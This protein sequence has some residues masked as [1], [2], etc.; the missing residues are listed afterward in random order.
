MKTQSDKWPV[1]I[2]DDEKMIHESLEI[3]LASIEHEAKG[4]ELLHAYS[5]EEAKN[6]LKNN[7]EIAVILLDVMMEEDT[8]GLELVRFIKDE[9]KNND[10][11]I[12]LNTG[13]P[14]I[15]PKKEVAD[16]YPI[17]GYLDKNITDN[18]D[19]Y[20]AVRSALRSYSDR[21]RLKES[22]SKT[23]IELLENIAEHYFHLL[24]ND[25]SIQ[26]YGEILSRINSMVH[27]SQEILASY[28]L[29]DLKKDLTIGTTKSERL[30]FEE[31][32]SLIQIHN[33]KII[34]SQLSPD[35]F[36]K[37][38]A[39]LFDTIM[40]SARNF[41]LIKILPE[42]SKKKIETYLQS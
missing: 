32:S 25:K 41:L 35:R 6:I 4:V 42:Q 13:Q 3:S 31:Y 22:A 15:A 2:V 26:K 29:E 24:S 39:I 30:S 18:D 11:R 10:V 7:N 40:N 27:C 14:G 19:T 5:K 20:A 1:L 8:A 9:I 36:Q 17:D 28:T 16:Q 38:I 37:E 23:D 21:L 34:L 12:L 33:I